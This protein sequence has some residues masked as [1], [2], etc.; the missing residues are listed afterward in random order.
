MRKMTKGEMTKERILQSAKELFYKQ[1]YE[2]TTIQQIAD[3]SG[4]TLGSMTYHFATKATFVDRIF[5]D[6]FDN[7]NEAI[8]QYQFEPWNAFENHFRLTMVYYN[9]LLTDPNVRYFYYEIHKNSAL[10]LFL[11]RSITKVYQKFVEDYDLRIRPIEFEAVLNADLGAR[12]SCMMAYYEERL[13]M[14]VDDLAIFLLTN[15][16]RMLTIPDEAIYKTS[17]QS[18]IFYREHDFSNIELLGIDVKDD[19]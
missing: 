1:G 18:L 16:A 17:Y 15:S 9:N 11:H 8:H 5:D 19:T 14:P 4:A 12:R 3:H 2:A 6:Y 7:I 13:N 10:F